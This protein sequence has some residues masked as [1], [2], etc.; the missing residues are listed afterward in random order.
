VKEKVPVV[1]GL[2]VAIPFDDSVT[3]GGSAPP[4]SD[5]LY[6]FTPPVA[7]IVTAPYVTPTSPM[8]NGSLVR[9]SLAGLGDPA[10][11]GDAVGD[12]DGVGTVPGVAVLDGLV[13]GLVEGLA[14]GEAIAS[15]LF[16]ASAQ[17]VN[18]KASPAIRAAG[19]GPLLPL[20]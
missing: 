2:P 8:W 13:E 11:D 15:W 17:A 5:H 10:G 16:G 1:V 12:P 7:T 14:D 20:P 3:P 6:G 4:S 19:F 18:S 9:I